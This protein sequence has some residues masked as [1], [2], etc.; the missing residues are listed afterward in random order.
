[1]MKLALQKKRWIEMQLHEVLVFACFHRCV[2]R[3]FILTDF[4]LEKMRSERCA[5]MR[6]RRM[7]VTRARAA[8]LPASIM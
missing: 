3:C 1:V 2:S 8:F 6:A 7:Q 4:R 5:G